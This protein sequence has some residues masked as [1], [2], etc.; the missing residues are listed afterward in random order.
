MPHRRANGSSTYIFGRD[1]KHSRVSLSQLLD[2]NPLRP[3]M[4][5]GK[6]FVSK[7]STFN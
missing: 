2:I 5:R 1:K 7:K 4:G 3:A 6:G